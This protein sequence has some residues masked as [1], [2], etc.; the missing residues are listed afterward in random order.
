MP[1]HDGRKFEPLNLKAGEWIEVRSREEVLATLDQ[2]ARLDNLPFMPEM[3]DYCGKQ[4]RVFK[5]ADKACDNIEPWS[6]RRMK[7]AVHL[8][9]VRCN[10]E[11]HDGCQAGC[12]IFWHEA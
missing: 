10:G 3:L 2:R 11:E 7:N 12:L 5:R 6:I 4:L 9:G 1:N 8:E